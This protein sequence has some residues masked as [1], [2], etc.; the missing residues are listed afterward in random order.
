MPFRN[1][2]VFVKSKMNLNTTLNEP[3]G[4]VESK[5]HL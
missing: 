5:S 4:E 2:L 1:T 3:K